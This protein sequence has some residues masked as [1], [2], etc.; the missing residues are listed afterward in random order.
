MTTL[1]PQ[2]SSYLQSMLLGDQMELS[3]RPG[4]D[5]D[6]D[7]DLDLDPGPPNDQ[8]NDYIIEDAKS[9]NT[10]EHLGP[11]IEVGNDDVMHDGGHT[12][13]DV[14]EQDVEF[15]DEELYDAHDRILTDDL[16]SRQQHSSEY[17]P[18]VA[19]FGS[20][21]TLYSR[22]NT[23][24]DQSA[25]GGE[26]EINFAQ[27]E[28]YASEN[29]NS[30]TTDKEANESSPRGAE[31]A[32]VVEQEPALN[33]HNSP[34]PDQGDRGHE[35]ASSLDGHSAPSVPATGTNGNGEDD[36]ALT[37]TYEE[38]GPDEPTDPHSGVAHI[39]PVVVI[40]EGN[41][42]S[43]FPPSKNDT[44]DTFFLPDE[45]LA[46]TNICDLFEAIRSVLAGSISEDD[47][48]DMTVDGLGLE[49][50][51]DS[52]HARTTTLSQ[53]VDL[54]VQLSHQDGIDEPDPLY[55]ALTTKV[56]FSKRFNDIA[57]AAAEGQGISQL[58]F[59]HNEGQD[60][61]GFP[62]EN[63][64]HS[65]DTDRHSG[66][67]ADYSFHQ[68][69]QSPAGDS[70][71]PDLTGSGRTGASPA[72]ASPPTATDQD[73]QKQ[74][75]AI[76]PA[77]PGTSHITESAE[78]AGDEIDETQN[79]SAKVENESFLKEDHPQ[80]RSATTTNPVKAAQETLSHQAE[81][82]LHDDDL[83][84]YDDDDDDDDD[85]G[86]A[87]Q[88]HS[89]GSSTLQSDDRRTSNEAEYAAINA[90]A[91]RRSS[92]G[93]SSHGGSKDPPKDEAQQGVDSD[94]PGVSG[95]DDDYGQYQDENDYEGR[96]QYGDEAEQTQSEVFEDPE[97]Y[98]ESAGP[99]EYTGFEESVENEFAVNNPEDWTPN[100]WR[101]G[102]QG[103]AG[104]NGEEYYQQENIREGGTET[105]QAEESRYV[106][107]HANIDLHFDE[108]AEDNSAHGPLTEEANHPS[109][110][111]LTPVGVPALGDTNI[112]QH[113]RETGRS[114]K[115]EEDEALYDDEDGDVFGDALYDI[116]EAVGTSDGE[117]GASQTHRDST[118]RS[119]DEI[120]AG[121]E[122]EDDRQ[123]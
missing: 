72:L 75:S 39:H 6:I 8:D 64:S 19:T 110:F 115:V 120:E 7:I 83:I 48:L 97:Q 60:G 66:W 54:H 89:T 20:S 56:R 40:Y 47:E 69:F 85:D 114:T 1:R 52:I 33:E 91:S 105:E 37:D 42:I 67:E 70:D 118:K 90:A 36:D 68:D 77:M 93:K 113:L 44:S 106:P 10:A 107:E 29:I 62:T 31:V 95:Y 41:E 59:W 51:E 94:Q 74:S 15:L 35:Q 76:R 12:F 112:V 53:I 96:Q 22:L 73:L 4:M 3:P 38:E 119:L 49:L 55:V 24:E 14:Q 116:D 84:D 17:D 78:A 102:E 122:L 23:S 34:K 100:A 81:D 82:E 103:I 61:G 27:D 99:N 108:E 46:R 123:G 18:N 25:A 57:S 32:L 87:G 101:P 98:P 109:G 50:S 88:F 58:P 11:S 71:N 92:A 117:Q 121:E 30:L 26:Q 9:E 13:T 65:E 43:L 79:P 104:G 63:T 45:S 28:T 16:S 80:D 2:S 111:H 5:D 21:G 86:G